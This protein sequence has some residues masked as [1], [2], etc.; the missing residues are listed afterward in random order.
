MTSKP[1]DAGLFYGFFQVPKPC[2]GGKRVIS[3]S[4]FGSLMISISLLVT[5]STGK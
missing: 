2:S 4:L 5:Q 1:R 3:F